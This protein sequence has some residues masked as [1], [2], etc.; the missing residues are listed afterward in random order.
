M[1]DIPA[2]LQGLVLGLGVFVCPGPKDVVIARYALL[3]HPAVDLIAVGVLSDALLICLGMSGVAAALHHAPTWQTVAL[4]LGAGLLVVHGLQAA[5]RAI[6]GHV[7]LPGTPAPADAMSRGQGLRAIIIVSVFNP[8][9]WLDTVLVVGSVGA[10]LPSASQ[11]S[12]ALGAT[13]ASLSWFVALVVAARKAGQWMSRPGPWRVLEAC[14][15]VFMIGL[16]LYLAL[17]LI[18]R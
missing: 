14:V 3:R 1:F 17:D 9:A 4:G 6:G 2:L 8:V 10:T 11:L 12:F 13:V 7:V 5:R 18:L 16:A 15:A